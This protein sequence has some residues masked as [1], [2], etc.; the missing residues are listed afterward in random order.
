MRIASAVAAVLCM[1]QGAVAEGPTPRPSVGSQVVQAALV[2]PPTRSRLAVERS[3]RPVIR[4]AAPAEPAPVE[5]AA[6]N[7]RFQLWIKA[8][9]PRALAQGISVATFDQAFQGVRYDADVIKRDRNQS[10]FTKT[11]W[12][13]LDSAASDVRIANGKAAVAKHR[14][15]LE[16]IEARYGV[17]KEVVAAIWGLESAYGTFRGSKDL[18][19]SLATLAFDTRRGAFFEQQLLAGLKI[20]QSGDVAPR[21]M[22]GSWAGAMGHTQFIPTSYLDYAVDFTGDGKRD[23][24]GDDPT[25]ALASTANYLAKFGWTKGQPWG[26][27][28]TL[29]Q[30]FD[31]ALANRKVL[32]SPAEWGAMGI[33][34]MGGQ[35]VPNHGEASIL[36]PAGAKGAAFMIFRN[37]EVIE[38]YNTAD[39]YVIGVG[40]LADRIKGG[41]AIQS[42]W[43]RGDRALKFDERKEMQRLLT[44]KGFDTKK[45]D[46]KIGPLTIEAVR[47]FQRSI[48][49]VPDGYASLD[50]LQRL[51]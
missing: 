6:S 41:P 36:L 4:E 1:A 50:I 42:G 43:P 18:V 14:S 47:G 3:L 49:M 28:V 45:I 22:T 40:H 33:K 20:L 15:T 12:D 29:P 24:W 51:R 34:N 48:G 27:E 21:S 7:A 38:R 9:R 16:R 31:Y 30:G 8:L 32:K 35:D 46:G 5:L 2:I 26:V 44:A 23:I 37:F 25:D 19:G 17:D 11:L 10:E 39:A 13:Y